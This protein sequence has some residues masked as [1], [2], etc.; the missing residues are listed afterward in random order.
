MVEYLNQTCA[1]FS[2]SPFIKMALVPFFLKDVINAEI[3][4][5][6]PGDVKVEETAPETF[7]VVLQAMLCGKRPFE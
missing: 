6:V 4:N 5:Q 2:A 3:S 1:P 7:S